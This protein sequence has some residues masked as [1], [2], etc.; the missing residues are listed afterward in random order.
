MNNNISVWDKALFQTSE[1][2]AA[3]RARR[4][5]IL[6]SS[7]ERQKFYSIAFERAGQVTKYL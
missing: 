1:M 5:I 3:S 2:T 6:V 4:T 7:T